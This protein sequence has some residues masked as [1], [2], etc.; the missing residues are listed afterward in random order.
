MSNGSVFVFCEQPFFV[1]HIQSFLTCAH[2]CIIRMHFNWIILKYQ[3]PTPYR[4]KW[5]NSVILNTIVDV[6]A[7]YD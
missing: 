2:I 6:D 1:P 5:I 3:M 4:L 7:T